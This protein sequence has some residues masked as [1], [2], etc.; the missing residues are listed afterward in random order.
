MTATAHAAAEEPLSLP[1]VKVI[2]N[3]I[4]E[5]A[6]MV[7]ELKADVATKGDIAEVHLQINR[8]ITVLGTILQTLENI[9]AWIV[10]TDERLVQID[11]RLDRVDERLDGIEKNIAGLN[12]D[13]ADIKGTLDVFGDHLFGDSDE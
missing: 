8:V 3:N 4:V 12:T 5:V 9:N 6:N 10:R 13:I 7:G 1:T 2:H 11:E